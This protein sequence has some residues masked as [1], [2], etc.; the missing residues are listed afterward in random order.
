MKYSWRQRSYIFSPVDVTLFRDKSNG[1]R[2]PQNKSNG[3][4]V[5]QKVRFNSIKHYPL[6]N[7]TKHR[8]SYFR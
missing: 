2:V 5:P 6:S 3:R 7:P 1:R 4:R 8:C